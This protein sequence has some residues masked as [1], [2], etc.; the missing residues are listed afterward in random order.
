MN[1]A[2]VSLL[3]VLAAAAT[4]VLAGCTGAPATESSEPPVSQTPSTTPTPEVEA[5]LVVAIDGISYVDASGT[6]TATYDEGAAVLELLEK[7]TGD[8]PDPEPVEPLP[9]YD[10]DRE[11]YTWDGMWV[12]VD[13]NLE[14]PVHLAV[15]GAEVDGIPVA[16]EEGLVVGSTRQELMDA[17]AWTLTDQEDAT[18]TEYLGIGGEEV[19]GT[20]SLSRPGSVGI[21]FVL[22]WLDGDVVK[23]IQA[24]AN[25]FSDI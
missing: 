22:Y 24:P 23:Q 18:T 4:V 16:S 12:S 17:N 7:V 6:E 10:I 5:H 15:T 3:T 25:D 11:L 13:A 9:G 21:V 8:L 20:E 19:Q 1:R 2:R 14:A